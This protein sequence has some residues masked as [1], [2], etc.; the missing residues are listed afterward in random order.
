MHNITLDLFTSG[1]AARLVLEAIDGIH[2]A[3]IIVAG[4]GSLR[5]YG[6]E[7]Y[8]DI[9]GDQKVLEALMLWGESLPE[10][11]TSLGFQLSVDPVHEIWNYLVTE[12]P[13]AENN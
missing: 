7:D 6:T 10:Q 13:R 8:P 4:L 5:I 11:T 3:L 1:P 2:T 9:D 12:R